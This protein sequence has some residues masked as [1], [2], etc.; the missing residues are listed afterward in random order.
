VTTISSLHNERV[1]FV[2]ALQTQGKTRRKER[3]CVLE[4]VRLIGDAIAIGV[5]PDLVLYTEDAITG[6]QPAAR[7]IAGLR[8]S[9]AVCIEVTPDVMAHVSDTQS[10]QGIVAVVPLPELTPPA[11]PD[12]ILVLDGVADPGNMGTILRTAAAAGVDSVVLAPHC[13]DPFNPKVL[14]G[15]MGAHFRIPLARK[16]WSDISRDYADMP[17]YLADARGTVPY[18][19]VDWILPTALIVGGE[20]RGADSQA[21]V[22]AQKVISIPMDNQIESL[23]AAIATGV[24]LF[25]IRRQRSGVTGQG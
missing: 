8:D 3:R 21:A 7:L 12:L 6:D 19:A 5:Q 24:I 2:H 16:S 13:V 18:Y 23:N 20:A 1:K 15:G 17:F 11:N 25:E 14:R 10:P 9:G 22:V 4:G